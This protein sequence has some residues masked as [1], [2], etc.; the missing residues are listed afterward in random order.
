MKSGFDPASNPTFGLCQQF[1]FLI[2]E[3]ENDNTKREAHKP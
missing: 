1:T 3:K 2:D